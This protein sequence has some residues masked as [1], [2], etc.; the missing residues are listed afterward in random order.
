MILTLKKIR[1]NHFHQMSSLYENSE[2]FVDF[3]RCWRASMW[4]YSCESCA[5]HIQSLGKV[6]WEFVHI[7]FSTRKK[8]S[9]YSKKQRVCRVRTWGLIFPLHLL[10][11]QNALK[12]TYIHATHSPYYHISPWS[13]HW[14]RFFQAISIKWVPCM[15]IVY[16]SLTFP[17][18]DGQ[19]CGYTASS[20]ALSTFRALGR[21][22]KNLFTFSF[23]PE[24]NEA[25]T[26]KNNVY[27]ESE[28]GDWSFHSIC[29]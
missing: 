18:V 25:D 3:S 17:G 12:T 23:R 26:A 7:F 20:L 28:L 21:S 10:L 27:V 2:C 14:R 9:W 16:V 1:S 22:P 29:Y 11:Y 13:Q 6:T 4:L 19:V 15:K 24:K 5:Q 8:W